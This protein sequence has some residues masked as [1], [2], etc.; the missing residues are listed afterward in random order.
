MH[1]Q[2]LLPTIHDRAFPRRTIRQEYLETPIRNVLLKPVDV[3]ERRC[4]ARRSQ[5]V[6]QSRRADDG[7]FV[8]QTVQATIPRKNRLPC[9]TPIQPSAFDSFSAPTC[10][11]A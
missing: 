11:A 1:Q 10:A 8:I 5:R 2:Q 7:V 4:H 9:S 3:S 6:R